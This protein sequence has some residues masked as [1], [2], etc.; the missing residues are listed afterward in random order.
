MFT[1]H[2]KAASF[3]LYPLF[4]ESPQYQ[5]RAK[6]V[7]MYRIVGCKFTIDEVKCSR[8]AI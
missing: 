3:F 4:S 5:A 2:K 6:S 1:K 7:Y 8:D